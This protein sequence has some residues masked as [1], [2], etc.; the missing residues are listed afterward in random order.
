MFEIHPVIFSLSNGIRVVYLQ[1]DAFVAHFGVMIQAGS[2]YERPDEEGLAHF[3]EHCIFKGTNKRKALDIFTDL[4]S[5][6][7]ELNAYTNKEE[8]CVHAS[9]RK[10]H[11]SIASEL[12]GD[13]VWNASFPLDE[14]IKEKEVVLDEIIS[15][16]DSPSERI[17][18]DFE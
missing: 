1:R 14:V 11:F 4:D 9:F 2:R 5:V 12:L 16:L 7:G 10:N 15:Y 17:F 18:D 6:G 13:I 8:I 3:I